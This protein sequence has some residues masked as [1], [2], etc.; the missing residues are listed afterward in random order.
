M[1]G[2]ECRK[3]KKQMIY[4]IPA[5]DEQNLS[6]TT[7]SINKNNLNKSIN[8]ITRRSVV[9]LGHFEHF[10]HEREDV[11]RELQEGARDEAVT[12]SQEFVQKYSNSIVPNEAAH[13]SVGSIK[14]VDA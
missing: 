12:Y 5:L 3:K 1:G 2:G 14:S 9:E 13:G 10:G 7:T 4:S 6:K 8:S 11:L